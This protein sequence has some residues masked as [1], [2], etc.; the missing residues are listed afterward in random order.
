MAETTNKEN[1]DALINDISFEIANQKILDENQVDKM[2]G[3]LNRD[4][5]YAW[6]L[7]TKKN[8]KYK[9]VEDINE[10][11]EQDLTKMLMLLEGFNFLFGHI[12]TSF[13]IEIICSLQKEIHNLREEIH[14]L[15]EEIKKIDEKNKKNNTKEEKEKLISLKND[16]QNKQNKLRNKVRKQNKIFNK[17]FIDL[18][19]DLYN[20][21]FFRDILDRVLTYVRYHLKAEG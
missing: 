18:S 7:Y 5:V 15:R 3:V 6:W 9:F 2:L 1:L 8:I 16:M 13:D 17:F 11:K 12:L 4:G 21:L 10:F 14:N 19:K 20:L